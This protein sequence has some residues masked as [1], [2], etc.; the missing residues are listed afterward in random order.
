MMMKRN[1]FNDKSDYTADFS[2]NAG[3]GTAEADAKEN[4]CPMCPNHCPQDSPGCGRGRNYFSSQSGER[5]EM[6]EEDHQSRRWTGDLK[7]GE[8]DHR[9][10]G[11]RDEARRGSG[12]VES[13]EY[14][15]GE[16]KRYSG[17]NGD[18]HDRC[19]RGSGNGRRGEHEGYGHSRIPADNLYGLMRQSGHYLFHQANGN[20]AHGQGRILHMLREKDPV[21]QRELQRQL[22]IQPGSISEI[23]NKLEEKGL[24]ERRKDEQDQR[25]VIVSLTDAGRREAAAWKD[26]DDN[27]KL[28]A[29]LSREEQEQLKNLL[30]KL[31][32]SWLCQE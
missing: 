29:A 31:V 16:K 12:R 30:T 7:H 21:S 23:L 19:G 10:R 18:F 24:I 28:F 1:K 8:G 15:H 11:G 5:L 9:G 27:G 13:R 2:E 4:R 25:R 6:D 17:N 26:P 20:T 22:G 32:G 14:R 3:A